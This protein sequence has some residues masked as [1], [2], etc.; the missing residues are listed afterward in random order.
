MSTAVNP[1][2]ADEQNNNPKLAVVSGD[3]ERIITTRDRIVR[4]F[5]KHRMAVASLAFLAVLYVVMIFA[6][7]LSPYGEATA[8]RHR[9]F[10]PPTPVYVDSGGLYV[11]DAEI[12]IDQETLQEV[13]V[14]DYSKKYRVN[15]FTQGDEHKIFGLIPT[16]MHL[17]GVEAPAGIY[18]FGTDQQGRDVFSRTLY[19]SR[20]SL[21]VGIMAIFIVIPLGMLIGGIAGYFGGWIDN[22][23]MRVVEALMAF[24]SFYLL[25]F[26]FGVTYKWDISPTQRYYL[27]ILILSLIG[28]TSLSRVI[29]GQVLSLKSMEYVEASI[30]TGASHLWVIVKHILPQ[31]ATWVTISASLMVPGFILGESALSMLGLGVQQPAASWGNLLEDARSISNLALHSWLLIPGYFIVVTVVAFNFLGDGIR[32]AFDAKS[33]A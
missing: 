27:I 20:V 17:F 3:S 30:A 1:N 2:N 16:T 10:M 24:P 29:R 11:R 21:T 9:S 31:T 15:F 13:V 22:A 33:R 28:W 32:D 8:N 5:F 12:T 6:D 4:R 18:L 19:G 14:V 26:L 25:L 23:L 7:V